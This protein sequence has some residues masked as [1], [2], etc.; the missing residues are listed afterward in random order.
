[1]V[2][3]R[4]FHPGLL[5]GCIAAVHGSVGAQPAKEP[6]TGEARAILAKADRA[7]RA[8]HAVRFRAALRPGG[9]L[10]DRSAPADATS[11][12]VGWRQGMPAR[13]RS[14]VVTRHPRTGELVE[15]TGG[16][17][18]D[19]FFL[20]DHRTKRGYEDTDPRVLGTG[21]GILRNVGMV[22]FV[23]PAPY[24]DELDAGEAELLGEEDVGGEVCY[25]IRVAF[26]ED[27]GES[28]WFFSKEDYL[29]RGRIRTFR[30]PEHGEG[31]FELILTDLVVNP[32][33][34]DSLF[35]LNLPEGFER[36]DAAAP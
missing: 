30:H 31:W 6:R 35:T 10:A 20:I 4:W 2:R 33:T 15:L 14:S 17:N 28:I 23:H 24:D 9:F 26:A 3:S 22:Q 13:F 29:P 12:L 27:A 36:I 16:R 21:A 5:L 18:G 34:N 32:E 11:I 25:R 19:T 7:A 8:V 1:M